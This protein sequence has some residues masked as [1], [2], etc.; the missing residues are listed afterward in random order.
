MAED[1][2]INNASANIIRALNQIYNEL[3]R[4]NQSLERIAKNTTPPGQR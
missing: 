3:A 2:T 1:A 4:L